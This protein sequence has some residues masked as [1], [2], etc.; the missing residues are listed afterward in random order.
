MVIQLRGIDPQFIELLKVSTGQRTA[1]KAFEYAA[2]NYDLINAQV[3]QLIVE[4]ATLNRRLSE[5]L[6]VIEG[7]RTAASLLLDRTGQAYLDL[8]EGQ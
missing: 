7:A 1:S 5:A 4:N 6:D 3:G 2:T 8:P